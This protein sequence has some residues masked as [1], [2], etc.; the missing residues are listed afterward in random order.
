VPVLLSY[1]EQIAEYIAQK[2]SVDMVPDKVN[3]S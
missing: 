1:I 2:N 3:V